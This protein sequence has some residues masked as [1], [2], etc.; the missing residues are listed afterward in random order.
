MEKDVFDLGLFYFILG[1]LLPMFR[2]KLRRINLAA[3][4]KCEQI[5]KYG[6]NAV[7]KPIMEDIKKLVSSFYTYI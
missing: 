5:K 4:A 6:I 1:N 3:I 7:L 2:S